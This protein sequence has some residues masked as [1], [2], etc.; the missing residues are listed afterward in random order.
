MKKILKTTINAT[1][2]FLTFLVICSQL[3]TQSG[4]LVAHA[5]I[6]I[7]HDPRLDELMGKMG[8]AREDP[9]ILISQLPD[10]TMEEGIAV[11]I[12]TILSWA[13]LFTIIGIVVAAI[14]FLVSQGKEENITKAKDIIVYLII[15]MVI[16]ASAYGIITGISQFD[17]FR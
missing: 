14:F 3:L 11:V 9:S 2:I 16:M 13:M 12:K 17:F 1:T 4:N 7:P 6:E 5:G 15:G 10:V 8:E